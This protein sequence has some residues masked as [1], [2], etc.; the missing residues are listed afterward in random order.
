MQWEGGGGAS[1]VS[2][3]TKRGVGIDFS[4]IEWG[5]GGTYCFVLS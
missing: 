4:H 1:Q 2:P 3:P 5:W